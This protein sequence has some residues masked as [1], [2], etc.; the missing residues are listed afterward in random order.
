LYAALPLRMHSRY[1]DSAFTHII[2]L[3]VSGIGIPASVAE[4]V[5]EHAVASV[6]QAGVPGATGSESSRV[7]IFC[8]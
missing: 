5:D 7:L 1:Q 2:A 4:K 6:F 8:S 3:E